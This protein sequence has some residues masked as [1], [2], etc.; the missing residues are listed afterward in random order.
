MWCIYAFLVR[1]YQYTRAHTQKRG[2]N[3]GNCRRVRV[4]VLCA[5]GGGVGCAFLFD[6][7]CCVFLLL[8]GRCAL[9][10]R[11]WPLFCIYW[12]TECYIH[13]HI[14]RYTVITI[15][16]RFGCIMMVAIL[17]DYLHIYVISWRDIPY[18]VRSSY[19]ITELCV[20]YLWQIETRRLIQPAQ[21]FS[22]V[23]LSG[24]S[25]WIQSVFQLCSSLRKPLRFTFVY[26]F[27]TE[28]AHLKNVTQKAKCERFVF[29]VCM[30][31]TKF[32]FLISCRRSPA[33]MKNCS[34]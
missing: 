19:R 24:W 4:C 11:R 2:G 26:Y 32:V 20:G 17:M 23:L 16:F 7:G 28:L 27:F 34:N 29:Y 10:C 9:H 21:C 22:F 15:S 3:I 31:F 13:R 14:I 25:R 30:Q 5:C 1:V 33:S 12:N 8:E 6:V 18:I